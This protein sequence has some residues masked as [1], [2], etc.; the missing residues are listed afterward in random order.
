MRRFAD[1]W[2]VFGL[3]VGLLIVIGVYHAHAQFQSL[4]HQGNTSNTTVL[5]LQVVT[6]CVS[7]PSSSGQY[8]QPYCY[9]AR[10]APGSVYTP[11]TC[12][13]TAVN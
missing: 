2:V 8:F 12:T 6:S 5:L 11:V 4:L 9:R 3:L 7:I 13:T 10:Y 1:F